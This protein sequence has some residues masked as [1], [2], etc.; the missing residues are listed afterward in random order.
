MKNLISKLLTVLILI[1]LPFGGA[2]GSSTRTM[3]A[4]SLRSSDHTK[5][6]SLPSASG[7]LQTSITYYQEVPSGSC[8][9]SNTSFTISHT[10]I[11]NSLMVF[12][13]GML[14]LPTTNYTIS[15]TTITLGTACAAGQKMY[16]VYAY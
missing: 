6:W 12:L 10:P 2:M 3:D 5:T 8:N 7:T 16:V 13:N 11:S 14:I 9:G 4:D 1:A 15:G